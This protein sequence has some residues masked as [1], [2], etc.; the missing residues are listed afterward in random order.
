MS[1]KAVHICFI[2]L[3]II[4][5][6][7]FGVWGIRDYSANKNLIHLLLGIGFLPASLGLTGYLVWF[8]YKMRKL[9]PS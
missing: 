3:S 6:A 4:L 8:V 7:G 1:L 2:S 9:T 5:A